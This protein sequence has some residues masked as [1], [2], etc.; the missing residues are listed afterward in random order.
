M[1]KK[2][3]LSAMVAL[4]LVFSF[5]AQAQV[6]T[7]DDLSLEPESYWN[8]SDLSGGFVSGSAWFYNAYDSTYGSWS[9]FAYSNITDDTTAGWGNQYSAFPGSGAS[10]SAN[11]AVANVP[12]DFMS[13]TF[14][15][16]PIG[17][18]LLEPLAGGTVKGV[19]VTNSTYA[20]LSMRNG[21]AFAKKFGGESGDDPD[22]FMLIIRGY[23]QGQ[24]T[25]SV[26]YFLADF[27]FEDNSKDY[28]VD[29]WDYVDLTGLG[30]VDSLTFSLR[31]S[32]VGDYG[33]N[34]PAYFCLD[35]LNDIS[36]DVAEYNKVDFAF[37]PNPVRNTLNIKARP[38]ARIVLSDITGSRI[39][40]AVAGNTVTRMDVS[41]LPK[42]I[43]LLTVAE[44][45]NAT[46]E[47][48][49]VQ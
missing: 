4:W 29:Y 49:I 14:D 11:Y 10:G 33:M 22:W 30:N 31:S 27:R 21:D 36:N 1:K 20:A 6:S 7:F 28:I 38:G 47:K 9:G 37:Y 12:T 19:Y 40:T 26:T 48:V 46:T 34:T 25:D 5:A 13:G 18:K 23:N 45:G 42:G 32:D 16:I 17:V 2:Y 24:F 8:G 43:Y 35:N 44:G 3:L 15:P 39:T 41:S